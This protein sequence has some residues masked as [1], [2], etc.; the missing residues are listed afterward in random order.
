MFL[1]LSQNYL[2]RGFWGDEAWTSLISQLPY[3]QMI[4]ATAADTHPPAYYTVVGLIYKFL[5]STEVVTR[6]VSIFFYLATAFLVYK[7]ASEF[8]SHVFGLLSTVVVLVNPIFFTYAFEAR[9][10]VMLAF[11]ATGSIYF[12][13]RLSKKFNLGSVF[14][15]LFFSTLGLYT[16]HY[17]IFTLAA[18]AL[19][20]I[21]FDRK[22]LFK[23]ITLYIIVAILYLPWIPILIS[24]LDFSRSV[25]DW[26]PPVTV[27]TFLETVSTI[28]GGHSMMYQPLLTILS[29]TI[30]LI[31][32]AQCAFKKPF[33]K[34]YLLIGLWA[35][36]PFILAALPG[37]TVEGVKLPFST[38][39]YHRYL[40]PMAVPISMLLVYISL[41][42][43][44]SLLLLPF[45]AIII[46][47]TAANFATF[48]QYPK[49]FKQIYVA[50]IV[51]NI[52]PADKIVT[53]SG[54]FAEV[55]YYRDKNNLKNGV[56]VLPESLK[57]NPDKRLLG[58][59]VEN[60]VVEIGESPVG[61]YFELGP[62][63]SLEIKVKK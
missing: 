20:L 8:K 48:H 44:K 46:L 28:I 61:R 3:A 14:Y 32:L 58:A 59:Y 39:F 57:Q 63:P 23:I 19:Y 22:I 10:Y 26:I 36:V 33:E 54:S 9:S 60:G 55:V 7:L 45:A 24:Q 13:I 53:V 42:Y 49:T 5:P 21:L 11:A 18:Q 62:G 52:K 16:H 4:K 25:L 15:F 6:S 1:I 34:P 12:L 27:R 37:L 47:S 38:I 35:T 43:S 41:R 31:G 2:T 56:F 50:E 30:L 40:I 51:P 17:M 29:T